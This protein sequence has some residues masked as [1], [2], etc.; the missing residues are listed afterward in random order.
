MQLPDW[1]SGGGAVWEKNNIKSLLE[2][3]DIFFLKK[4]IYLTPP[5]T[6]IGRLWELIAGRFS[7]IF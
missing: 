7:S 6:Q 1:G 3:A 2:K 4:T 5:N